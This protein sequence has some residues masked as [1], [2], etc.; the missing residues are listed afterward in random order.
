MAF[1]YERRIDALGGRDDDKS[2]DWNEGYDEALRLSTEI[3]EDADTMIAEL[4]E[5]IDEALRGHFLSLRRWAED[6][7]VLLARI[8]GRVA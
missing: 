2:D 1:T 3:G 5:T 4:I 7:E 6:A 8:K